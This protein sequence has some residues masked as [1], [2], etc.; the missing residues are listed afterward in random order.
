MP[1]ARILAVDDSPTVLE[2]IKSILES[3]EYEVITATDGSE[4]LELARSESPDLIVLDVMLPKLDGYKV[5]RLLKYDQ[6]YQHIPIVMLTA[7]A[8]EQSMA[9]GIR[10][11]ADQ[12]LT[13][14][15][16]PETLL[17]TVAAELARARG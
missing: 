14:P 5:C 7:K 10:T 9:T 8:E 3:G 6:K 12:Y 15:V 17:E 2:M 1:G 4:A 11:G 13:K 16:E